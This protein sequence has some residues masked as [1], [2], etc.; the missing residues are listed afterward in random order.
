MLNDLL[1]LLA[2]PACDGC[3]NPGRRWCGD[4]AR[5]TP[6]LARIDIGLPVLALLAFEGPVRRTIIDWKERG[7]R[8]AAERL[9]RWL[10][11]G[12]DLASEHAGAAVVVP[13]PP[14]RAARRRRGGDPLLTLTRQAAAGRLPVLPWL[15]SGRD[16]EDQA[17]LDRR[18]RERNLSGSLRWIGNP[19]RPIILV[20]DVVTT[21][22]TLRECTRAARAGGASSVSA[23]VIAQREHDSPVAAGG[24][25]LRLS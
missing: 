19:N 12:L 3:G 1:D 6:Q 2:T 16:R 8:E 11:Q 10:A 5:I 23:V 9:A 14:S 17:G 4:C 18:Q 24:S 25:E 15:E 20:D 13:V 7:N 22:A 21:G